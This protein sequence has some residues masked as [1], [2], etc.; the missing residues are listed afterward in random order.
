MTSSSKE[1]ALV[2]SEAPHLSQIPIVLSTLLKNPDLVAKDLIEALWESEQGQEGSKAGANE[3]KELFGPLG[4][5]YINAKSYQ[6]EKRANRRMA[7][8]LKKW[9]KYELPQVSDKL[10][11][12]AF[13]DFFDDTTPRPEE[14]PTHNRWIQ[15]R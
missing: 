5:N 6:I 10:W 8:M 4:E 13:S 3:I 7:E 2:V 9:L 15:R 14:Y 12:K 11:D 1:R